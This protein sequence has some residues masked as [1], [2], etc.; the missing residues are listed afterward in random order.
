[1]ICENCEN[2]HD[3][4]YG[5]GRFCSLKCSRGFSTKNNRA[6]INEKISNSLRKFSLIRKCKIC[7]AEFVSKKSTTKTCKSKECRA[8]NRSLCM[9]GIKSKSGEL[10]KKGSGGLRD[11]GGKSKVYEYISS[12]NE[13]MFLNSE[14]LVIANLLDDLKTTWNRNKHGFE[15]EENGKIR[16]FY[17]DFY[18]DELKSYVEYKG[19]LTDSMRK[20]MTSAVNKNDLP[21]IIVV[22]KDVRFK[23]DGISIEDFKRKLEVL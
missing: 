17:P 23:D 22:G 15:Y 13:K 9:T 12:H 21:L 10:R 1:M 19:W 14:E 18:V 6:K 8:I 2:S 20:K 16:K 5:S 4:N 3:G 7:E 11:G